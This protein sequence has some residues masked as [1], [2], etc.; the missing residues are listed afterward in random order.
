MEKQEAVAQEKA[1]ATK[2]I[3]E[4]AQRDLDEALPA[5][6]IAVACLQDLKKADIDE[7]SGPC[8]SIEIGRDRARLPRWSC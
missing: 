2:A 6:D 8:G 3:A 1:A 5:L 7:V 4:D